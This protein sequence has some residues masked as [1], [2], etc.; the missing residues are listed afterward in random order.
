MRPNVSLKAPSTKAATVFDTPSGD[1][2]CDEFKVAKPAKPL[3]GN[4]RNSG[5]KSSSVSN[6]PVRRVLL[7]SVRAS[8]CLGVGSGGLEIGGTSTNASSFGRNRPRVNFAILSGRA[9]YDFPLVCNPA[10]QRQES[11]LVA[12]SPSS[13][14]RKKKSAPNCQG[15]PSQKTQILANH[16]RL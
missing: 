11:V 1:R 3:T 10:T 15:S 2:P 7:Q 4:P 5:D 12:G 13:K 8:I 9:R 16:I 14:L 6:R